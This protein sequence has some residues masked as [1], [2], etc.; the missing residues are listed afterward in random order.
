MYSSTC[1]KPESEN[2]WVI[3]KSHET[4]HSYDGNRKF[5]GRLNVQADTANGS[6]LDSAS[7]AS[8]RSRWYACQAVR[9]MDG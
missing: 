5:G 4:E 2:L 9:N 1:N 3:T 7:T 8:F 6:A